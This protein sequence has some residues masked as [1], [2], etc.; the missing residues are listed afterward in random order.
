[1]LESRRIKDIIGAYTEALKAISATVRELREENH[2]LLGLLKI[3][4]PN[5]DIKRLMA[6]NRGDEEE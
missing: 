2:L 5:V 6:I 3:H 4:T 1:M